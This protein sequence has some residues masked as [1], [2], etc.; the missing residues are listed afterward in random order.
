MWAA[1][2]RLLVTASQAWA[3]VTAVAALV[4][5]APFAA[6]VGG[7]ELGVLAVD[8]ERPEGAGGRQVPRGVEEVVGPGE[9]GRIFA[10]I[11]HGRRQQGAGRPG[12]ARA[13]VGR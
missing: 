3:P 6:L 12:N 8:H 4:A 13:R 5:S 2:A 11:G 9:G 10:S 1:V 7:G